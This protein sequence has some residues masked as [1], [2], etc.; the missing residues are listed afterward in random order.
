[1][2]ETV[3]NIFSLAVFSL[4]IILVVARKPKTLINRYL[5][6]NLILLSATGLIM[7]A[8]AGQG[9]D[10]SFCLPVS[11]MLAL[12][13]FT[14][15]LFYLYCKGTLSDTTSS[16]AI[17]LFHL[18]IPVI[19]VLIS[20][21]IILFPEHFSVPHTV[22]SK[23][24]ELSGFYALYLQVFLLIICSI[25]VLMY[26][27]LSMIA[28]IRFILRKTIK[29]VLTGQEFMI[30]WLGLFFLLFML[31]LVL[32][33]FLFLKSDPIARNGFTGMIYL[34]QALI[35]AGLAGMMI[36]MIVRPSVWCGLPRI[37][38]G[39][40]KN[41][42]R[43]RDQEFAYTW[44]IHQQLTALMEEYKP[45]TLPQFNLLQLSVLTKIPTHHLN[46]FF[47]HVLQKSFMIFRYEYRIEHARNL[48]QNLKDH[49]HPLEMIAMLS[50]YSCYRKFLAAFKKMTGSSAEEYYAF[51]CNEIYSKS[52]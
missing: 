10:Q 22:N 50:G 41:N 39:F 28:L 27:A 19:L 8:A 30:R 46:C 12:I 26:S 38:D 35:S 31:Q 6:T 44:N 20:I 45:Y 47:E 1:M 24:G 33:V 7:G 16:H 29:S 25:L 11:G 43:K 3:H 23:W 14:A 52:K 34:M 9:M 48:M 2:P 36:F 32:P 49:Q 13:S 37:P 17:G 42:R 4:S 18:I 21:P 5:G 51:Y 15:P 40:L